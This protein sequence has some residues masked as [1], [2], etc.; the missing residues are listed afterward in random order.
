MQKHKDL[1]QR[2]AEFATFLDPI[3]FRHEENCSPEKRRKAAWREAANRIR[4]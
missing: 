1:N 3:A 2:I 4:R